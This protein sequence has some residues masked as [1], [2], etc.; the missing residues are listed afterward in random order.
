MAWRL[1]L[2]PTLLSWVTLSLMTTADSTAAP[3]SIKNFCKR[4][5]STSGGKPRKMT[6]MLGADFGFGGSLFMYFKQRGSKGKP[7]LE[8]DLVASCNCK[9]TV[10]MVVG[11]ACSLLLL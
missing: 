4:S 6:E 5:E 10:Q 11:R 3:I 8:N 7:K 2:P 1:N 9:G